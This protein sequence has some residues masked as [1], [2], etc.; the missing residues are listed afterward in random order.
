MSVD[1]FGRFGERKREG[2]K[3]TSDGNYDLQRKRIKFLKDPVDS[4]DAVNLSTLKANFL[5]LTTSKLN[6]QYRRIINVGKPA[7]GSDAATKQFVE[8]LVPLKN[9]KNK[10]YSVHQYNVKDVAYP[11]SDGDAV[12]LKYVKDKCLILDKEIDAKNKIITNLASA[13]K[14]SD[15]VTLEFIKNNTLF[16]NKSNEFDGRKCTISNILSPVNID[17]VV[18]KR[19]LK[20]VLGELGYTLYSRITSKTGRASLH[21]SSDWKAKVLNFSWDDLFNL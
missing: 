12:N 5:P 15:A 10:S 9:V 1:K 21:D 2:L 11:Q 14:P 18:S 8:Y 7:S 13:T 19:Y 6:V 4:E 17:D 3:L 20:E 16:K